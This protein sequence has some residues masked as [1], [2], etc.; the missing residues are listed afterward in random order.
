[1][2]DGTLERHALRHL[3]A[4]EVHQQDGVAHDD[5]GQRNHADHAGGGV[6]RAE[7][8][9]AGH[10]AN[11]GQRNRRH[12]DQR[13]QVAA[14]LRHHQQVDQ[15]QAHAIGR[16]HVAKGFKGDLPFAVPLQRVVA[17]RILGR[18]EEVFHQRAAARRAD[19]C[20]GAA[21]LEH[22]VQRAVDLAR[23]VGHHIVHRQQVL[24]EH[25]LLAQRIAHRDQFAQRH[26][27]P[28]A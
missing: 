5:A 19:A 12:D 10:H 9:M 16:A 23:H 4:D 1:M 8:R 20:N 28:A 3:Q 2:H 11:D 18:A 7:Q 14:E 13:R 15:D 21:H 26:Q 22:A 24:V 27:A 25:R 6:L 17:Q